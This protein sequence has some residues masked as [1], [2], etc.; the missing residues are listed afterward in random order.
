MIPIRIG[1]IG[2]PGAG[3]STVFRLVAGE[4][5][6]ADA[7]AAAF[8]AVPVRTV[9]IQDPRVDWLAT[10][11]KSKKRVYGSLELLD[12][13]WARAEDAESS[14]EA[15]ERMTRMREVDAFLCVNRAFGDPSYPY[16]RPEA[17]PV[18]DAGELVGELFLAD[19][20]VVEGRL[21]KI[22]EQKKKARPDLDALAREEQL[23]NR[24]RPELEHG[25]SL[26]AVPL[27]RDEEVLL[28]GFRLLSL[29][30]AV[31]VVNVGEGVTL[32]PERL[33]AAAL[34][35]STPL[36]VN[37]KLEAELLAL[38]EADR[39]EL[40]AAM[41]VTELRSP[42]VVPA[43]LRALGL[44]LFLTAGEPEARAWIMH[45]GSS[46]V[47]A[48]GEIH[49]DIAKSFIKAEVVAYDD[50]RALGSMKEARAHGKVRLEGK[51]YVM[52]DGDVVLFK[53]G[54]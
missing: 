29:K 21:K 12:L 38:P 25:R 18:R 46:A 43:L 54:S 22:S 33:A 16:P 47:E 34:P 7:P 26:R 8:G 24:L 6:A 13:A 52:K 20:A 44:E 31:T 28:R 50:L 42:A 3:K 35:G 17:D 49:T 15:N 11:H 14:K 48:A 10:L 30:P 45:A 1:V 4:G 53:H 39:A 5:A 9:K 36:E 2:L 51:D 19:L 37:A 41:G 27:H 23:L 32:T 40:A